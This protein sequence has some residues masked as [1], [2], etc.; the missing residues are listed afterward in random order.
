[1]PA[2]AF[3]E[4]WDKLKAGESW[5]GIVK[6]RCK[7]GSYYWVDA[8]V[9]PCMKRA[10]L[11]DTNRY[12]LKQNQNTL[13]MPKKLY[14]QINKEKRPVMLMTSQHKRSV[15]RVNNLGCNHWL[16]GSF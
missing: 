14:S 12:A 4:L 2:E 8:F 11:L 6:N 13:L 5:R 15:R 7:D 1:M 3:K 10:K 9:S 16:C